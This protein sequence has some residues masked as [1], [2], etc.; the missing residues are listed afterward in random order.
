MHS[1]S[2]FFSSGIDSFGQKSEKGRKEERKREE[3]RPDCSSSVLLFF[4]LL[5]LNTEVNAF[6]ILDGQNQKKSRKEYMECNGDVW[7]KKKTRKKER[8]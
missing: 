4:I 3:N 5:L 8:K 6:F 7:R 1:D 2:I